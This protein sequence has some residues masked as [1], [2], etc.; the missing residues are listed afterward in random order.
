[1]SVKTLYM[2]VTGSPAYLLE[3]QKQVEKK[4]DQ[5]WEISGGVA[6]SYVDTDDPANHQGPFNFMLFQAMVHTAGEQI[7]LAM[8]DPRRFLGK[9]GEQ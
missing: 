5:G 3:F 2:V 8:L 6:V 1:M 9:V 4:L 7:D